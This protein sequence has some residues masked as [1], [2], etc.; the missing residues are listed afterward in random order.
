MASYPFDNYPEVFATTAADE[1]AVT[2]EAAAGH[3]RKLRRGLYTNN[4]VDEPEVVVRRNL[5]QVVALLCPGSVV[6][7]RTALDSVPTASGTVFVTGKYDRVITAP[8]LKI[9][10]LRGSGPLEGDQPF[11]GALSISS[12][13]RAFLECLSGRPKGADSPYLSQTSIEERLDRIIAVNEAEA[14]RIRDR[15]KEIKADLGANKAFTTLD[16]IVGALLGTRQTKL[17]SLAGASRAKGTPYDANR[18]SL[19]QSLLSQALDWIPNERV[20]MA[21]DGT[22][23]ANIGF[24]DAYFSNFIE[25][26]EFKLTEARAIVFD[27]KI[28]DQRP[29]DAHDILG[30]FRIVANSGRL[31]RPVSGLDPH[32]FLQL[33]RDW[34]SM[35]LAARPEMRPGLFKEKPNQAGT[36]LFVLPSLVEGTLQAGFELLR[37]VHSPFARAACLM[38]LVTEVHPF[39]DGNGRTARAVLNAE[40]YAAEQCRVIVPTVFRTEYIDAIKLLTREGNATTFFRMLDAAQ[41]FTAD[42]DYS[43]FEKAKDRMEKWNAFSED[44]E[45]RLRRPD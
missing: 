3:I 26:T 19:F 43:D 7:H 32:R 11:I 31:R 2:K 28:P 33:L 29:R 14:N 40:L 25:G 16:E 18:I 39:D 22:A 21:R 10:Q 24:F 17:K 38:F 5:W 34:H 42:I 13:A 23:L 6:S 35:I 36:T 30:T 9:R 20:D 12:R 4:R 44:D 41:E 1:S 8:G 45:A 15:A 27:G 37:A